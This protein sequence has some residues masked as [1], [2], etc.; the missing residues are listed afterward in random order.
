LCV[1]NVLGF[2]RNYQTCAGRG[3]ELF[4][5]NAE[6]AALLKA[7]RNGDD[8]KYMQ[9]RPSVRVHTHTHTHSEEH[10]PMSNVNQTAQN[11]FKSKDL[12]NIS[13]VRQLNKV[14][15]R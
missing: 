9:T 12:A 1:L 11:H 4:S 6:M 13:V 3:A 5:D 14:S 2:R 15:F 8:S 10:L 7:F